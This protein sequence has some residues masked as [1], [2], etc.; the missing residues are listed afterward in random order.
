MDINKRS[1][2]SKGIAHLLVY[3]TANGNMD[4]DETYQTSDRFALGEFVIKA[5]EAEADGSLKPEYKEK[6]Q[7]IGFSLVKTEQPWESLYTLTKEYMSKNGGE[8]PKATEKTS[9]DILIGA[10]VR[11]Q[12]LT[13]PH[14]SKEKQKILKK[15]GISPVRD[16]QDRNA[17]DQNGQKQSAQDQ[18]IQNQSTQNQSIQDQRAQDQRAQDQNAHNQNVRDQSTSSAA[19]YDV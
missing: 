14:L 5:R 13:Y 6:L 17:Q 4:V 1:Y 19:R 12:I 2:F 10:W 7:S 16:E 9:E 18:R 11:K 3:Q 8:L 15:I